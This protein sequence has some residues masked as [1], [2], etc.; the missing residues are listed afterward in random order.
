MRAYHLASL[1]L[2]VATGCAASTG[3]DSSLTVS[4]Q[5][6][7]TIQ[8][9]YLTDIGSSTWGRNLLAG[10]VLFPGEALSL[11]VDCG[12]YDALLV[13][14]T[15]VECELTGLD[16]CFNDAE[17]VIRNNTCSVFAARLAAEQQAAEALTPDASAN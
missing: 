4:N 8:E 6:D 13:D 7:F 15:N 5:S 16:L 2:A 11:G 3:A 1:I 12:T 14:E 17:W 10:D 9:L